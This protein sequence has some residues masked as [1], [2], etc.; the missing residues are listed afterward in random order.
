M[1]KEE[2]RHGVAEADGDGDHLPEGER[3]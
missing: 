2:I 3:T 1:Q